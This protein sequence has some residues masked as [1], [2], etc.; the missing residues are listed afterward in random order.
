MERLYYLYP[1][2]N[3]V[4][5]HFISKQHIRYLTPLLNGKAVIYE[6]DVDGFDPMLW[7]VD[8]KI[9]L[10]PLFYPFFE[11]GKAKISKIEQCIMKNYRIIALDTA[12]SNKISD[13]AVEIANKV[14]AIIVPSNF[15]KRTFKNSGVTTE[16]HVMPH[17]I[18][19]EFLNPSKDITHPDIVNLYRLKENNGWI[20]VYFNLTH[21]GFRKG[22]DL[23]I[24]AMA[25]VQKERDDVIVLVK[26]GDGIDPYMPAMRKLRCVEV[27][28]F[29]DDDA[30]RQLYD[31]CDM[32]VLTSRGGGFEVNALEGIARGI[33]TIVPK[34]GCF[35]DYIKYVIGVKVTKN[36]PI[37]LPDNPIHVGTGWE[38]DVEELSKTILKVADKLDY[39]KERFSKNVTKIWEKY[40]WKNVVNRLYSI[41]VEHNFI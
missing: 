5:F 27:A 25:E 15:A 32:V 23:F 10:H 3:K 24:K 33:P 18:P 13:T 19:D 28:G 21:S 12:D 8:K 7:G 38:V 26:R 20:F 29:L 30:F 2:Y 6:G 39:Y 16:V 11:E 1:M 17:G 40:A 41:L 35:M 34:A 22:A 31:I 36:K 37:V 14:E 9:I 4:S